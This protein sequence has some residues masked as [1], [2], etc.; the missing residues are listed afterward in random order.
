M[1]NKKTGQ[2]SLKIGKEKIGLLFS[3]NFWFLMD[4]QGLKMENLKSKLDA[5]GGI[6][7]M[8]STLAIIIECGG[9]SYAKKHKT[10]FNYEKEEINDWFE[11][12]INEAVLAEI[13]AVMMETKIFGNKI[14]A[15]I[16]RM[17]KQTPVPKN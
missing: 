14:N 7:S 17:G 9:H 1:E 3:M 16:D 12:D 13:L 10:E 4:E 8:L 2:Y 5:K 11:E 6:I 15:G